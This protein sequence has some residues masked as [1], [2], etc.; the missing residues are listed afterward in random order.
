[1]KIDNNSKYWYIKGVEDFSEFLIDT[2][3]DENRKI[4]R[5]MINAVKNQLERNFELIKRI[6]DDGK[7]NPEPEKI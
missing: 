4:M 2:I 7:E 3:P 1:M 5:L 6:N